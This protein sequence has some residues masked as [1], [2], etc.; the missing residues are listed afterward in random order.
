VTCHIGS[1]NP[2]SRLVE[3]DIPLI[4]GLLRSGLTFA[5]V[6]EKFEVSISTIRD[7]YYGYTWVHVP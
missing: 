3:S 6:A 2:K 4:R 1:R 7:I 5:Q